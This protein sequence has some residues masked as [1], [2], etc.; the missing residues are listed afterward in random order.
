MK[1][2][3]HRFDLQL[4][5]TWRISSQ[6]GVSQGKDIYPVVFLELRSGDYCGLG[7][8]APSSRYDESVETVAAFLGKVEPA[9]LS[10]EDIPGSMRYL[11][12]VAPGNCT[13]K[14]ALNLALLD[15]IAKAA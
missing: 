7:E 5:H 12:S 8:G 10:F 1:L 15:G 14:A 3:F 4:T 13:A 11:D 9:K 2:N 6:E